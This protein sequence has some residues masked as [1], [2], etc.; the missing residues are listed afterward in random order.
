MKKALEKLKESKSVSI[1]NGAILLG[2]RVEEL[3]ADI[4][5][6]VQ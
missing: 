6:R 4:P 2:L 5:S 1:Q 3:M